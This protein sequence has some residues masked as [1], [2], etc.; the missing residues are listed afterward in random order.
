[1]VPLVAS[2]Y[3]TMW[4]QSSGIDAHGPCDGGGPRCVGTVL[5][6]GVEGLVWAPSPRFRRGSA[7]RPMVKLLST[8]GGAADIGSSGHGRA[9]SRT[10]GAGDRYN[11]EINGLRKGTGAPRPRSGRAAAHFDTKP[12]AARA[13]PRSHEEHEG[14]ALGVAWQIGGGGPLPLGA[15]APSRFPQRGST[16][17]A[18]F[19]R[20]RALSRGVGSGSR[21]RVGRF[22]GRL[23]RGRRGPARLPRRAR[24]CCRRR[25]CD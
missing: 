17:L 20:A 16:C 2:T 4:Y 25:A 13:T 24:S 1:L 23:R 15:R 14:A 6:Q 10:S 8:P 21:G 3:G 7:R 19:R 9:A 18:R 5:A 11:G 12:P 22:G